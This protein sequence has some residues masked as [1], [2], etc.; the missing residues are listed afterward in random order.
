M[1]LAVIPFNHFCFIFG[2]DIMPNGKDSNTAA[3]KFT[4]GFSSKSKYQK[5]DY[6]A[7]FGRTLTTRL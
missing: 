4:H 5:N 6:I 3:S 1:M 7:E 2:I